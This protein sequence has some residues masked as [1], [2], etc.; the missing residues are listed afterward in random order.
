MSRHGFIFCFLFPF[1]TAAQI[2][3][4]IIG[5]S[6]FQDYDKSYIT[7]ELQRKQGITLGVQSSLST[8][9][10]IATQL[11]TNEDFTLFDNLGVHVGYNYL[12]VK[13]RVLKR[14]SKGKR[15]DE[16]KNGVGFHLGFQSSGEWYANLNYYRPLVHL[17]LPMFR[18]YLFNEWGFGIYN[19]VNLAGTGTRAVSPVVS[20]EPIRIRLFNTPIYL[21]GTTFYALSNDSFGTLPLNFSIVVG[22]RIYFYAYNSDKK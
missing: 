12:I 16:F 11:N 2:E 19:N 17:Y 9:F 3:N 4:T 10:H 8:P 5:T 7:P 6:H 22:A 13:R 20:F 18:V 14:S 21:H 15:K 1:L